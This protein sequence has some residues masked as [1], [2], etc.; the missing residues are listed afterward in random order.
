MKF[1]NLFCSMCNDFTKHSVEDKPDTK[2]QVI[3]CI[4]CGESV[5]NHIITKRV[6][7]EKEFYGEFEKSRKKC[8]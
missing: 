1:R 7:V 4:E 3:E 5:T 8:S 2:E 6:K